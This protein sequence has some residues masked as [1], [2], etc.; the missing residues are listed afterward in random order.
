MASN[1]TIRLTTIVTA[2]QSIVSCVEVC[3]AV[4]LD[5]CQLLPAIQD[6][7]FLEQL[8]PI[9]GRDT[10]ELDEVELHSIDRALGRVIREL[11]D[12]RITKAL[13]VLEANGFSFD[14]ESLLA[15]YTTDSDE[16]A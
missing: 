14:D 15:D 7:T 2:L 10:V 11:C 6:T 9:F 3:E 4:Q 12:I 16:V 1:T 5:S 13:A 8:N